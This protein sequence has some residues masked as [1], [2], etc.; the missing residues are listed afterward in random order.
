M[1]PQAQR[2]LYKE[3]S[4]VW[5]DNEFPEDLRQVEFIPWPQL[6]KVTFILHAQY[7][8]VLHQRLSQAGAS[9]YVN[10]SFP[11]NRNHLISSQQEYTLATFREAQRLG[12]ITNMQTKV[13]ASDTVLRGSQKPF[14][15]DTFEVPV[16]KGSRVNIDIR[17]IHR[18]R[19]FRV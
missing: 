19:E 13:V 14:S 9:A 5:P 8:A 10:P 2:N 17:A 4:N 1:Y 12:S 16:S 6:P 15:D 11:L 3:V 7:I 18:A